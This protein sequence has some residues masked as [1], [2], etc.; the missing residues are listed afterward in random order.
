MTTN[1]EKL[2]NLFD[3]IEIEDGDIITAFREFLEVSKKAVRKSKAVEGTKPKPKKNSFRV[4][5]DAIEVYEAENNVKLCRFVGGKKDAPS[6]CSQFAVNEEDT[7]ESSELRCAICLERDR[8]KAEKAR[9]KAEAAKAKPKTDKKVKAP[10]TNALSVLS[11]LKLSNPQELKTLPHDNLVSPLVLGTDAKTKSYVFDTSSSPPVCVGK[12]DT[13]I[14]DYD[15]TENLEDH[16]VPLSTI[17]QSSLKRIYQISYQS[18]SE[19]VAEKTASAS[20]SKKS[21]PKKA[22]TPEEEE[23]EP[24]PEKEVE[25]A[26]EKEKKVSKKKVS[27]KEE[28]PE[29]ELILEDEVSP[30]EK[31]TTSLSALK[32]RFGKKKEPVPEPEEVK[33]PETVPEPE[34]EEEVK[35]VQSKF[36][37]RFAKK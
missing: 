4:G 26:P 29:D 18:I 10:S 17:E 7:E 15:E 27:K 33:E 6:Y 20:S 8:K 11:V 34:K 9:E 21:S 25:P 14:R 22:E 28:I 5:E 19:P 30:K 16:I 2:F 24:V 3:S 23:K 13:F 12:I 1:S 35:T 37:S 31:T 36:K 32:S